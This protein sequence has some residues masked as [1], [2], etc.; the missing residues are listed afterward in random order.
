MKN[1]KQLKQ[2][3]GTNKFHCLTS[4]FTVADTTYHCL[5]GEGGLVLSLLFELRTDVQV[6][7]ENKKDI[8]EI[9]LIMEEA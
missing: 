2:L 8:K 4:L 5:I 9:K 3:K 6:I 1:R 7:S